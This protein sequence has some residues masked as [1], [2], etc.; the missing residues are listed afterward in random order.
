M[1]Q[2][3]SLKWSKIRFYQEGKMTGK[4]DRS[5][6]PLSQLKKLETQFRFLSKIINS[7]LDLIKIIDNW[8]ILAF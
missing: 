7:N 3:I 8:C 1:G 2:P 5:Y 4:I 6:K